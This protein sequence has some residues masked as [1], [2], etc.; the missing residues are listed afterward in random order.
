LQENAE[1]A[2]KDMLKEI[3]LEAKVSGRS[4][5]ICAIF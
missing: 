3:A 2:V 4:R 5:V 1:V